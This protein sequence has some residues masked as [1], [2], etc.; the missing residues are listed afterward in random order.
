MVNVGVH[1]LC[2]SSEMLLCFLKAG[3]ARRQGL[4]QLLQGLGQ[5]LLAEYAGCKQLLHE[6]LPKHSIRQALPCLLFY[7]IL[8]T[9]P[10]VLLRCAP[11][12][13][14]VASQNQVTQKQQNTHRLEAMICLQAQ[15]SKQVC[16]FA[17]SGH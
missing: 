1:H 11:P 10:D 14:R 17:I 2:C 12:F 16:T 3:A 13:H 7:C 9:L 8:H 6:M 15:K 4:L 5:S